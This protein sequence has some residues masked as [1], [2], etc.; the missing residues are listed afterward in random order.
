MDVALCI[1][2]TTKREVQFSGAYRPLYILRKN[3]LER[4]EGN[5]F[6]IGGL[7]TVENKTFSAVTVKLNEGE[8]IYMFSDGYADQFGG[9]EGKKFMVKRFR[10]VLLEISDLSMNGQ[11]RKLDELFNK[12]KGNYEQVD[13]ILIIGIKF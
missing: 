4:I 13:D 11:Q 6:P 12:W 10:D 1:I 8:T 5:K 9:T 3:E 2:D 7:K